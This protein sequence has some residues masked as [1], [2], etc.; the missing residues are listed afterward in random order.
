VADLSVGFTRDEVTIARLHT[1]LA[2]LTNRRSKKLRQPN[3][4]TNLRFHIMRTPLNSS[5]DRL[6][7]ELCGN[8]GVA[9]FKIL[10]RKSRICAL[11]L[12]IVARPSLQ[13]LSHLCSS[14]PSEI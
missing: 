1:F 5:L 13:D 12:D 10:H 11:Y 7:L 9:T 6:R 2:F 4:S 8:S 14:L 3:T